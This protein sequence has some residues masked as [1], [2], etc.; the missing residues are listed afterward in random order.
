MRDQVLQCLSHS[1]NDSFSV[2]EDT[3]PLGMSSSFGRSVVVTLGKTNT[4]GPIT[5]HKSL[6]K[7]G[8][9]TDDL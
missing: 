4:M 3:D 7:D 8:D 9:F 1:C 2:T 5:V 6:K